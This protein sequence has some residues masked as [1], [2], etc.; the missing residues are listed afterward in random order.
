MEYWATSKISARGLQKG[1]DLSRLS[2]LVDVVATTPWP[3]G[4]LALRFP[5]PDSYFSRRSSALGRDFFAIN[6]PE[7][8]RKVANLRWL[9]HQRA[10]LVP[11][12][13]DRPLVAMVEAGRGELAIEAVGFRISSDMS[14][15][16][17]M[18]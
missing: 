4:S 2:K 9:P 11:S 14:A 16:A 12:G 10:A 5:I 1:G 17:K 7:T 8:G 15:V 13:E 18:N 6:L 3:K